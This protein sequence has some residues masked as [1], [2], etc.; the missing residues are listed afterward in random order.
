MWD[1][2]GD[3]QERKFGQYLR[4][5]W[6]PSPDVRR[7]VCGWCGQSVVSQ[8]GLFR[9]DQWLDVNSISFGQMQEKI[10]DIRIC[11]DCGGATTFIRD[12]QYPRP[13]LGDNLKYTGTSPD[14]ETIVSLY[15][16]ARIA[17][18]QGAWSC[19][20]LMFRKLLMHIAVEQGAKPGLRFIEYVEFLKTKGIVGTPMHGLLDRVRRD[21]NEENHE[22]VRATED[23][24]KELLTLV[25]LLIR[26][27]YFST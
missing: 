19:S 8:V 14:V 3:N 9:Q 12:V 6:Q 23:K 16:E 2:D 24:A 11:P 20:V 13:L 5:G 25:T 21:G 27:V 7:F 15:N 4:E 22:V 18:S 1:N 10:R 17:L 26:S